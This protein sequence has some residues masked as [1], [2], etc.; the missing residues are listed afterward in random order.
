MTSVVQIA[1]CRIR[2]VRHIRRVRSRSRYV[3]ANGVANEFS[4][5]SVPIAVPRRTRVVTATAVAGML[6]TT[7]AAVTASVGI[8]LVYDD[9]AVAIAAKTLRTAPKTVTAI[10]ETRITDIAHIGISF[11]LRYLR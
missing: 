3:T 9:I 6:M 7:T 1:V 2:R 4:A 11:L 10:I 5:V 8:A